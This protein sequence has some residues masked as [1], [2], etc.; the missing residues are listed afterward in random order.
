MTLAAITDLIKIAWVDFDK[1]IK[2]SFAKALI[3]FDSYEVM[4]KALSTGVNVVSSFYRSMKSWNL[5][6]W[7]SS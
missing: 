1:V 3:T 6:G 5:N 2:L 7:S 4:E